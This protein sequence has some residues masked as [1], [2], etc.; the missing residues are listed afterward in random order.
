MFPP[1]S[2]VLV[3]LVVSEK[4]LSP[5]RARLFCPYLSCLRPLSRMASP[6]HCPRQRAPAPDYLHQMSLLCST[7]P[8]LARLRMRCHRASLPHTLVTPSLRS[9]SAP[10]STVRIG[11]PPSPSCH[12][13][14]ISCPS[15]CHT[16]WDIPVCDFYELKSCHLQGAVWLRQGCC[17]WIR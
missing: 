5:S 13:V 8:C 11:R 6:H 1:L 3:D 7:S 16:S 12:Q 17:R 14:L 9:P 10:V 15:V 2:W 4:Y